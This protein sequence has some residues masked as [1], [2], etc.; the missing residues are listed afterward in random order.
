[1]SAVVD[2]TAAS[3]DE[4]DDEIEYVGTLP[5]DEAKVAAPL[6]PDN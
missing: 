5:A 2:L 1:M 3:D 6:A 4:D